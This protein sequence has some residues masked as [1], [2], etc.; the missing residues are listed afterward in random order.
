MAKI[1]KIPQTCC[2]I[3]PSSVWADLKDEKSPDFLHFKA[4][5]RKKI[6]TLIEKHEVRHFMSGMSR[7]LELY[8]AEVILELRGKYGLTFRGVLPHEAQPCC[9]PIKSQEKYYNIME[10]SDFE[11]LIQYR[12][13]KGCYKKRNDYM[14]TRSNFMLTNEKQDIIIKGKDYLTIEFVEV[15][16]TPEKKSDEI[17]VSFNSKMFL[18]SELPENVQKCI[19]KCLEEKENV[20]ITI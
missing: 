3:S 1:T 10:K 7:G 19:L 15:E 8:A 13:S 6:L 14:K 12:F 16:K 9:W 5:I 20:H 4:S 17:F 18:I 11:E 2:I